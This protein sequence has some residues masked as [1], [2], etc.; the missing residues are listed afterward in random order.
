M[1]PKGCLKINS[2]IVTPMIASSTV[3]HMMRCCLTALKRKINKR[4]VIPVNIGWDQ[5]LGTPGASGFA[6]KQK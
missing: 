5:L 1:N 2:P 6:T 3:S 4:T